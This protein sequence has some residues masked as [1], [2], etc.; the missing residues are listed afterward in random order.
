MLGITLFAGTANTQ[1][2]LTNKGFVSTEDE[3]KDYVVIE[4]PNT[5]KDKLFKKTE[6]YLNTLYNNPKFVTTK[7]DNEQIVIDALDAKE[8]RIIFALDGPNLWQFSYKYKF[9]FKDNKLRFIP[10]FKSLKNTQNN[11]E[12]ELIGTNVM[13][14]VS[15]IFNKKGKCLKE[16]AKEEIEASVN[17]YLTALINALTNPGQS[18]EDW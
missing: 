14:N 9:E 2:K 8:L 4:V 6:M 1:F 13:G 5:P 17:T 3:S 16:K 12:I 7:V 18:T 11:K 15:G 10:V